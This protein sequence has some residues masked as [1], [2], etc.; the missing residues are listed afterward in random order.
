[1]KKTKTGQ[2]LVTFLG[3]FVWQ[4]F[5]LT[6]NGKFFTETFYGNFLHSA[7]RAMIEKDFRS[8]PRRSLLQAVARKSLV[9]FGSE[10]ASW[11]SNNSS[12]NLLGSNPVVKE[13]EFALE[14]P[15]RTVVFTVMASA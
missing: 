6:F 8:R 9:Q 7:K 14:T 12:W 11:K 1:M 13:E 2:F 5:T 3:N 10:C 15:S 4:L